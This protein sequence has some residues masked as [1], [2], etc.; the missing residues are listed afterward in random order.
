MNLLPILVKQL[1]SSIVERLVLGV[2]YTPAVIYHP[3][4]RLPPSL[5]QWKRDASARATLPT[6]RVYLFLLVLLSFG[7]GCAALIYE[8]VW[9]QLLQ[10]IIGSSAISLG[11]LLG[12]FMAG[13]CLGSA[14]APSFVDSRPNPLRVYALL[15][16][17]IGAFSILF[18]AAIPHLS[19]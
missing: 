6:N 18:L 5:G 1:Y 8:V 13:L 17:S 4:S 2:R 11:V 7:S 9:F 14:L 3:F 16:I 12:T 15:E 19:D 10:I